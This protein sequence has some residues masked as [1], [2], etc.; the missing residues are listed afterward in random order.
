MKFRRDC[1]KADDA[2]PSRAIRCVWVSQRTTALRARISWFG[3]E[4]VQASRPAGLSYRIQGADTTIATLPASTGG[5]RLSARPRYLFGPWR[6][7]MSSIA[8]LN[9]LGATRLALLKASWVAELLEPER[10]RIFSTESPAEFSASGG[11][12]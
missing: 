11:R 10:P 8:V 7:S 4:L 12:D 1:R 6:D 5:A 9:V 2:Y 3:D